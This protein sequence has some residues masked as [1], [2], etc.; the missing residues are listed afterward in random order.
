MGKPIYKQRKQLSDLKVGEQLVGVAI[1]QE[2]LEGVT[3]PKI[4]VECGIGRYNPNKQTWNMVNAML[5]LGRKGTKTS[6]TN[7]RLARLKKKTTMPGGGGI[8]CYV[9]RTRLDSGQLEV[10]LNVGDVPSSS[11]TTSSSSKVPVSALKTG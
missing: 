1:V 6:V 3:G 8:E 5:R 11:G 2:H 7:K 10:V 4:F 9:S